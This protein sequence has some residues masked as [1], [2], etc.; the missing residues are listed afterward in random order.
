MERLA[1][2]L[3]AAGLGCFGLAAVVTGWLPIASAKPCT[4]SEPS[5]KRNSAIL[6]VKQIPAPRSPSTMTVHS[7]MRPARPS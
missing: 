6:Y 3:F 1:S 5:V 4:S 2:I 7:S